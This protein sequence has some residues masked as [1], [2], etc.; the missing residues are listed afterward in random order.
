MEDHVA[1]FRR[2]DG[3]ARE[4]LD[5]ARSTLLVHLRFLDL[6]L[7]RFTPVSY[8]GTLATDGQKLFY[9][10]Y[11]LLN[12]YRQEQNRP[13]RDYL[14]M[15]L[16]CVFHHLF[17][18]PGIDRR[19]WDL[20]CDIAVEAAI[21]DL[22]LPC[23]ACRRDRA[24]E[25]TLAA[26]AEQVHPL[27]AEKLYRHLLD[28]N[29]RPD[30]IAQL[31]QPFLADDHR[32]WYLP[33]KGGSSAGGEGQEPP[34][35]G[36]IP[37][38]DKQGRGGSS[39]RR[40]QDPRSGTE[41]RKELEKAWKEISRRIQVDLETASRRHG[42]DAGSLVQSLRPVT[43]EHYDY[44]DFLRRYM[45]LGEVVQV[46][47][48]E[49]DYIFYTYGLSLYGNMPLVEPLEYKEVR[50]IREFVVAIDTSGSVS[51]DLVQRFVTKTYNIL[52]QQENFF[53]KINLHIIQCDAQIQEDAHI[54][55][56]RDFEDYL[57]HMELHGFGGTDFRPVFQYVDQLIR[58][59]AFTNLRGIIYF[60]DGAGI[61]PERKPDYDAAFVFVGDE[62]LDPDVPV[63]AIKLVLQSEE[64]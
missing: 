16:H 40:K 15:V 47:N 56:Q 12:A 33:V 59:G 11:Y 18:G 20:A 34:P 51:G 9:D 62:G 44:A 64:I 58:D 8:P 38:R 35:E 57:A 55:C 54:T 1:A 45:S 28:Q 26:L 4:V 5:L 37:A 3:L 48:D 43:R 60:T 30:Q 22:D 50:R 36:G 31:R 41:E 49:F 32:A 24:Q 46:N 63:W 52:R 19:C 39:A 29:L 25:E 10:V 13:V 6:A 23:A 14:H 61:F 7:S 27:T 53:T 42:L 17:T 21:R 2:A